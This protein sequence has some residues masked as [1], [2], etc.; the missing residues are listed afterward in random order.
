MLQMT[1]PGSRQNPQHTRAICVLAVLLLHAAFA[2][3]L[4]GLQQTRPAQA[5]PSRIAVQMRTAQ[6]AMPQSVAKPLPT[7]AQ[8]PV[9]SSRHAAQAKPRAAQPVSAALM[10]SA[11]PAAPA[12]LSGT[13]AAT[14][15]G[16]VTPT[17]TAPQA[18]AEAH[19]PATTEAGFTADYLHNPAPVY[20]PSSRRNGEE[21]RVLLR[22]RVSAAGQAEAVDV[23][24][25][26]G[27]S[28]LDEAARE[29]VANWRF[30]PARRGGQALAST[31]IVPITFRLGH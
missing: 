16:S 18:T 29:A 7:K 26:S 28:R 5:L 17:A 24:H 31:V 14:S 30:T 9:H 1:R 22:V 27:F 13:A 12:V 19:S 20:P 23:Q 10:A 6:V 11:H 25:G 2:N 3:W 4:L 8:Q 15:T 21:G